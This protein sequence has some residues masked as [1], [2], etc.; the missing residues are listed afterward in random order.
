MLFRRAGAVGLMLGVKAAQVLAESE[1]AIDEWN[2]VEGVAMGTA[3][4]AAMLA[5]AGDILGIAHLPVGAGL[6]LFSCK[7]SAIS[8][9]WSPRSSP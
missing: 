9:R 1:P 7:H 2:A 6:E 4:A 5:A 8:F 3:L